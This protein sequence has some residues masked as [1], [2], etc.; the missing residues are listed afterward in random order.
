MHHHGKLENGYFCQHT[1]KIMS[2]TPSIRAQLKI[3]LHIGIWVAVLLGHALLFYRFFPFHLSLLRAA[4]NT[5]PMLLLFY[6]N[7]WLVDRYFEKRYFVTYGIAAIVLIGIM[8]YV[9]VEINLSF[10][11]IDQSL[12][13]INE[14]QSWLLGALL[15]N[16][17]VLVISTFYQI[18]QNRYATERKNQEIINQQT[19]AQLQFLRAQINPHF[20]FNTLNNIYALAVAK[21]DKTADMVLRLSQLLRYIIYDGRAVKV[22]LELEVEQIKQY[23]E[24]FQLRNETHQD[25][26]LT[27]IGDFKEIKLEPMILIPLVEN[28]FKHCDFDTNDQAFV[29]LLLKYDGKTLQFKTLNT[30]NDQDKQKDQVGGVGLQN[31]EKRLAL[32]YPGQH[33]LEVQDYGERFEV[34]LVLGIVGWT[35]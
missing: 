15:T 21:S 27:T 3:W 11:N 31:I 9:R 6:G 20:L 16:L 17:S 5:I 8:S 1:F 13:F 23:I 12:L 4:G 18:L 29:H 32:N 34:D 10:P 30:K 33:R 24:L 25:I 35:V 14:R 2:R 26:Q 22:S 19:E 28:C 7:L